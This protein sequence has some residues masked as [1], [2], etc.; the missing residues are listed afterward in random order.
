MTA[1]GVQAGIA[2]TPCAVTIVAHHVGSV[3]GMERQLAELAVGL[4]ALGHEVT[5]IAHVCELPADAGVVFHRVRGPSRPFL[6]GYPWFMLAGSLAVRRWR[7]GV[8]QATGAI[9][10]GPVD[11]IAVHYCHQVGV[12]TPSRTTRLFRAHVKAMGLMSRAAERLCFRA[13]A[14]ATFVCVSEGVAAEIREHYPQLTDRVLTIHN[15][16]DT[17]TF[18]P[19][20]HRE[21]ARAMRQGLALPE[22]RLVA[23]FVGSEWK[24]KGLA[25]AI[26][27]LASAPEWDLVVA[28]DGDREHYQHFADELGVGDRVHWLGVVRDVQVVYELAD[29]FV[30]PSSYETFSLVTFEAAA[31]GLAVLATPVSGVRE[32]IDDGRNG[33]LISQEPRV[34]AERLRRL[35]GDP[36]L[37]ASL[38]QAAR[39]S[40]LQFSWQEMVAKHHELYSRLSGQPMVYSDGDTPSTSS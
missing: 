7:R 36:A 12:V 39:Q 22:E 20:V 40:A 19:G 13:S 32:L 21:A 8:V 14:A 33:F 30:L 37:K 10:V 35:A 38:G 16:V 34:I 29:A 18:A 2:P 3:G 27:A 23:V 17:D 28:G 24:R 25:P 26:E 11:V 31:S 6:L 4:R 9:V 15:G 5:V 1:S